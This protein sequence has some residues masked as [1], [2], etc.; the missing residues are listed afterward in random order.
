MGRPPKENALVE[1]LE[2]R[3]SVVDKAKITE[4]ALAAG[5]KVPEFL[6]VRALG[7]K[8]RGLT[9]IAPPP[10]PPREP[11]NPVIAAKGVEKQE[12]ADE[13]A[14]AMLDDPTAREAFIRRRTTQ[15]MGG[16]STSLV[17]ARLA[18]EEWANR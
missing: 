16:G 7:L 14:E 6:R 12:V 17:A 2:F 1:R 5:M 4:R 8:P 18:A 13:I 10:V 15:L 9:P 3:V 11:V